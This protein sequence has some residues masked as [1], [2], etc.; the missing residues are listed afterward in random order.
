MSAAARV[1]GSDVV[2]GRGDLIRRGRWREG[3]GINARYAS[4]CSSPAATRIVR[5]R[6][7]F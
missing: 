4:E 2:A 5:R 7:L 6:A 3:V 1:G